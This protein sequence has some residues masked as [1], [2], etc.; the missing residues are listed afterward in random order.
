MDFDVDVAKSLDTIA[1]EMT[2]FN[3]KTDLPFDLDF[4]NDDNK[5]IEESLI[6][7][8]K[9][10]L[11]HWI[12][13]LQLDNKVFYIARH[14]IKYGDC[15][16]RKTS[17]FRKW[18]YID[19]SDIIG[20]EIGDDQEIKAYHLRKSDKKS[21]SV[22]ENLEIVPAAGMVHFSLSDEMDESG[23]FG[24]GILNSVVK[25][26]KQL[27]MLE[28]SVLIY[29]IARAPERRIFYIETGNMPPQ[30]QKAHLDMVKNEFKQKQMPNDFDGNDNID[31]VFNPQSMLEDYFIA[32][33]SSAGKGSR[34]ETLPG[35]ESL[36]E[37]NDMVYFR[38]KVFRG[39]KIPTSYMRGAEAQG[40]QANDGKVGIAYIEELRFSNFVKRLQNKI[41]SV[42]DK[43][44]KIYLKSSG[45]RINE[46]LFKL[47]LPEPQNFAL[48]RQAQLDSE[49]INTFNTADNVK[50]LSKR[51]VLKKYLGFTE[52][53]IQMNEALIRQERNIPEG[54]AGGVTD[55]Q[56]MYDDV[57]LEDAK[58]RDDFIKKS[59]EPM[60]NKG[61]EKDK[62]DDSED[63]DNLA[64]DEGDQDFDAMM[65]KM[66]G[67]ERWR[68]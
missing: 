56:L 29:R 66:G 54:G 19:P 64:A 21:S 16:F 17:D 7:T 47:S 36:G 11:R 28:D 35:G 39:L 57:Y 63:S 31:A 38:D 3:P 25:S 52:E 41:E 9:A 46:N 48:Y 23:P 5:E 45:I 51:Y 14:T 61:D 42:F 24:I 15:F 10:A 13:S 12:I 34:I 60:V 6:V 1:E 50:Y 27:Q 2:T 49:L 40:A 62:S 59:T 37:I 65:K 53:D 18:T 20:I 67:D 26:Y 8:L 32:V 4:M 44:F 58:T 33:N 22:L 43:H 30:K 55:I 68:R